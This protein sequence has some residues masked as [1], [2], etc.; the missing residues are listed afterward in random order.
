M[1]LPCNNISLV[2]GL[3]QGF[4]P[5]VATATITP[6][7][8]TFT[9]A[10]SVALNCT[11]P[12]AT[13]T[14]TING[15]VPTTNSAVYS[16]PFTLTNSA[17]VQAIGFAAGYNPSA[18][19]TGSFTVVVGAPVALF[20]AIPTNG[21]SP[22]FVTFTDTST[23]TI[24]NRFWNFG[25]GAT[26][27]ILGT[28][29]GHAYNA[30][31]TNTVTLIVSGPAGAS[32]NTQAKLIVVAN[33]P[34]ASNSWINAAGGGWQDG[35]SWSLGVPPSSAQAAILITNANSKTVTIDATTTNTPAT[36]VINS[37]TVA[38]PLSSTN[39][40][41]LNNA[42][43]A[44]P[45]QVSQ[46]LTI[47]TNGALVV[48]H[49]SV[50]ATNAAACYFGNAGG[51]AALLITN[52]GSVVVSNSVVGFR[53]TSGNNLVLVDGV[54][55]VW[56]NAFNLYIGWGGSG[57]QLLVTNGGAVFSSWAYVGQSPASAASN[58][59]VLISG[60]GSVWSNANSLYVG[61][62]GSGNRLVVTNGG[63]VFAGFGCVGAGN[64]GGTNLV[65]VSG[66]GSIWNAGSLTL[67]RY[68]SG[69]QLLVI[70][71]GAVFSDSSVISS[72]LGGS[73]NG[74]TVSGTGSV[75]NAG[76]LIIGG[77]DSGNQVLVTNGGVVVSDSGTVGS[78]TNS[79]NN[80]ILITGAGSVWSTANQLMIG[81]SACS[82][83]LVIAAGGVAVASNLVV[84]SNASASNN[85]VEIDNGMLLVTAVGG[86]GSLVL[87]SA[88]QGQLILNAG[89]VTVDAL[90]LTNGANSV[91]T[92]NG[93]L[94]SSA[95]TT[96]TNGAGFLVG[97]G[98]E[99]ANFHLAGG[100]HSFANNLEIRNAAYLTGC[101]T[102]NGNVLVDSGGTVLANCPGGQLALTGIVTNNAT[103]I[104]TNGAT[105]AF[106]GLV[107]NN[108]LID[109]TAGSVQFT[110]G[111][112]NNGTIT[113]GVVAQFSASPTNGTAP[114]FVT[115]TETSTGTI[116]NWYWDF[117]DGATTNIAGPG[118]THTYI[119]AATNT[120]T[121]IVSG[122]VG[123]STNTQANL[124]LVTNNVVT[125]IVGLSGNLAFGN[126]TT[127][128][129]ATATLTITNAGNAT[130][131]VGSI[132][133]PAGFSGAFSGPVV[134][135][136]AQDV[137]VTF[138]PVLVT[139]YN[140]TLTVNSDATSGLN[141]LAASGTGT[142]I[143]STCPTLTAT[144]FFGGAGD[145]RGTAIVV[146]NGGLFVTGNVQPESQSAG[147]TSLVLGYSLP[148]T[149]VPT[150][151][152]TFGSGSDFYGIAAAS[153]GIFAAGWSYSLTT[154]TA[155]GKE[156][157]TIV[158]QFTL[159]GTDGPGP[160]GSVWTAGS[161]G[162]N[163]PLGALF[164]YEGV[165]MFNASGSAN[166][167]GTNYIYAVGGGQPCS[168]G[169]YFVVKYD[170]AGNR[171]GAATD[172][173]VGI[174]FGTCSIPSPGG[175]GANGVTFLNGNVYLVGTTGWQFED[176]NNRPAIWQYNSN[177]NL[178]ARWRDTNDFGA[179]NAAVASS[180]AVYAVGYVNTP[181]VPG[182]EDYLIVKYDELGNVLWR[183]T[184]GGTNTDLLTGVV[185]V[186]SRLF[187]VG[188]TR[189]QGA[190]GADAVLMEID[191]ATGTILST[192]LFGGAQDDLAN[193]VATDGF[194]LYLVGET[195]SFVIG[196][197]GAG[198]NDMFVLR[199][200]L[201]A[202]PAITT[203][204][205]LPAGTA[206][207]AYNL[208]LLG[209]GGA[210]PYTWS[211]IS[212][213]LPAGLNLDG[214]TGLISGTPTNAGSFSF[215]VQVTDHNSST[216][217]QTFTLT[218]NTLV[219][220]VSGNLA[221]GNVTTGITATAT[222]TIT[223]AGTATLT[224]SGIS[225]PAG[226][227]GAFSGPVPAGSAQG[228]TV[229]FAPVLVTNYSGAFTVN[230]DAISGT[231]TLAV[232]GT[233][234]PPVTIL[235]QAAPPDGGTVTGGGTYPV[236]TNILITATS[237]NGWT[238]GVWND[239]D[240]NAARTITVPVTNFIFTATFW[241]YLP[242][243]F[244]T[245]AGGAGLSGT[246]DGSG[247]LARFYNP[248]GVAVDRAGTVYVA[249]TFNHTIR[250]ITPFGITTTLAGAARL[251]AGYAD[252]TG[253]NA[254]FN[255]PAGIAMGTN[256]NLYVV[257][258]D[259][260]LIR[261]ITPAGV[262]STFAGQLA[263][264]FADG[265]GT[266]AVFN[267]PV[268][269]AADRSGN[270]YV[271]DAGNAVIR[272]ITPAGVVTTLAGAPGH[273]GYADGTGTNAWF[274]WPVG[275]AVDTTGT[276]YVAD[277][278]NTVIRRVTA[279]GAVTTLAGT[280]GIFGSADGTG[281]AAHFFYPSGVAVDST[282]NVYVADSN[283][284]NT[285]R[286]ITPAGVVTTLAGLPP[287]V[288]STDGIGSAVRFFDPYGVAVD[289]AGNL[290][291]ADM[292][293]KT[294]RK[295]WFG[296]A[297]N[298]ALTVVANPPAGGSVTGAGAYPIGTNVFL[299]ATPTNNWLFTGWSDGNSNA[300][301]LVT[302]PITNFIYIANFVQSTAATPLLTPAGGTFTDSV[303][304]AVSCA[305][306]GAI[307]TYTTDG[308]V[309]TTNSMVAS[310]SFTL[311]NS[312]LV[313]ALGFA[314]GY[315]LSP[316]ATGSF[317]VVR[318][319]IITTDS[320]LPTGTVGA[321]YNLSLTATGGAPPYVW[322]IV[323]NSLPPG[324]SLSGS[325]VISG[326]PV[327]VFGTDN[328]TVQVADSNNVV[329][330]LP[331]SLFLTPPTVFLNPPCVSALH[332][333]MNGVVLPALST[334]VATNLVWDWG[335]G[336]SNPSWFPAIH[337]YTV[338]S[339]YTIQVTAYYDDGTTD[340]TAQSVTVGPGVLTGCTT[341][342]ITA[343][344]G[345]SVSYAASVGSGT[346]TSGVPVTLQQT[347]DTAGG[348][349]T[350]IPDPGYVFAGWLPTDGVSGIPSGTPIDTNA[351]AIDV[352]IIS[353]AQIQANFTVPVVPV[354]YRWST[355]AGLAGNLGSVDS[356]GTAARFRAPYGVTVAS[357]TVAYVTDQL[358][359]TIRELNHGDGLSVSTVAG[360]VGD[361][362]SA[363][364]PASAAQFM[365]P[366]GLAR[367]SAGN[368]YVAD[369]ANFTIRQLTWDTTNLIW[370]AST[371]AGSADSPGS[372]DGPGST[373]QFSYP[374]GV[375]VDGVGNVY[376]AD[377]GNGTIRKLTPTGSNWMVTTIAGLAENYG[378]TDGTNS[379]ARFE[380]P[381]G[382]TVDTNG[383][384][385]VVD[386]DNDTLRKLTPAGSNWVVSTIAGQVGVR[387]SADGTNS[388]ALFYWP[389]GIAA[390]GAGNLYVADQGNETI[391]K[392][393]PAGPDWIVTTIGGL[394]GNKGSSDGVNS[395]AQF[396]YPAGLAVDTSGNVFV[397]D[398]GN[399]TVRLGQPNA[400]SPVALPVST[401]ASGTFTNLVNVTLTC[402]TPG[403]AIYYTTDGTDPQTSGTAYP[404]SSSFQIYTS[405][406]VQAVGVLNF[407][408]PSA[409]A[410]ASFTVV[411]TPAAPPDIAPLGGS[412]S[413]FVNV[414]LSC[415]TPGSWIWYTTD[416]TDP[417][418]SGTAA[419][420]YY[421][422]TL[423]NSATVQA[424]GFANGYT[425]S[426][427]ATASFA[428]ATGPVTTPTISPSGGPVTNSVLVTLSCA[429]PSSWL[430]YTSDG[431]DPITSGTASYYYGPFWLY[432]S[433]TI[434]AV[435]LAYG[436]TP[437]LVV[438]ASFTVVNTPAALP[439]ISTSPTGTIFTNSVWVY[440]SCGT[441]S[442]WLTYT[443][444]GSTPTSNSL[445]FYGWFQLTNSAAVKAVGFAPGYTPSPVATTNF[446]VLTVPIASPP[447]ITPP[448]GF[449]SDL[450]Q[451]TMTSVTAGATIAYT[452]DGSLPTTNSAV[453][454]G[455]LI[456]THP[457][458]VRAISWASGHLNSA[459]T[460][461]WFDVRPFIL[462]E[463]YQWTT[464]VGV[465]GAYGYADG[466]DQAARFAYPI[467]TVVD[468]SGRIFVVDQYDDSIRQLTLVGTNW[469]VT[470]IAGSVW[471]AGHV[472]G[473]NSGA[474]FDFPNGIAAD[475]AGNLFV[476]DAGSY[477]I[478]KATAVG[479]DWVV[480]TIA[481]LPYSSGAADGA[482][483]D[484]RFGNPVSMAV[485]PTGN[486]YVADSGY[487]TIRKLALVGT[488]WVVTTIAGLASSYGSA[489]G[490]NGDAQFAS[491]TGLAA[492]GAGNLF[493]ADSSNSTIR[494]LTPAGTNWVVTTIAG[495]AGFPGSDDGT[496]S[497][498]R[499]S[500]P[501]G[502]AV[503]PSGNLFV[504]DY[505]NHT[506]RKLTPMGTNW[507]VTTIGG[508]AQN[509]GSA[510]GTNSDARFFYPSGVAVDAAG[511]LYVTD[512]VNDTIRHGAPVTTNTAVLTVLANPSNAGSVTGGGSYTVGTNVFITAAP[513][514]NW[515]FAAWSDGN[516]NPVRIVTIPPTNI[517]FTANFTA[518]QAQLVVRPASR[519]FGAV[520][521]GQTNTQNFAVINTGNAT[522]SG[523]ASVGAPFAV[524]AGS[525]Y[526]VAAGGTGTVVVAFLPVVGGGVTNPV[527][528]ASNGGSS[529]NLVTGVG[530][531]LQAQLVVRP[532]SRDFG[533]VIIGQTNTQNF[534]VINTGNATLSG[535]ASVGAPFAVSAGSPYTV[536]AG[537]TGTVAV[538]FLPVGS[539]GVSNNVIFASNG[540]SS[541]NLVTGVGV[542]LQVATPVITPAGG[543]FTNSVA[544]TLSCTTPGATLTY[545][546]DGSLP[547]ISSPVYTGV[548]TLTNSATVQ[549]LGVAAGY[550]PSAIASDSFTLVTGV[551][552]ATVTVQA[553]PP[554]GGTVSGGGTYPVGAT[555]PIAASATTLFRGALQAKSTISLTGN[556]SID[557]YDS[558]TPAKSTSGLYD[559]T[560]SQ[561]N[562]NI[563]TL[564]TVGS[565][566]AVG[567]S[568]A[569]DGT[570]TTGPGG[571]VALTG[572]ATV[573]SLATRYATV[574]AATA[575][576]Y[577]WADAVSTMPD[578]VLPGELATAPSLGDYS[579]GANTVTNLGTVSMT[580]SY[581]A[582]SFVLGGSAVVTIQGDVSLFVSGA[583]SIGG[584]AQLIIP[585][586][587]SLTIYAGG[588]VDVGGN[589]VQNLSSRPSNA[590]WYGLRT[591]TAW[592]LH[593][594]AA[595]SGVVY[596]PAAAL[597]YT[598]TANGSG[599]L[600][601][602]SINFGGTANFHYDESLSRASGGWTFTGWN[603][604]NLSERRT[605]T[606]PATNITYT[607]NF[608]PAQMLAPDLTGALLPAP[609]TNGWE[610]AISGT[611]ANPVTGSLENLIL[612]AFDVENVGAATAS[613]SVV[614]FY[615]SPTPGFDPR[616]AILL[617][618]ATHA[619][620]A[621]KP[622][623]MNTAL[624]G[625]VAP[626][627]VD[628]G[629]MYLVAVV[630]ATH[631]VAETDE[632][633]NQLVVGPLN[634]S[635][636]PARAALHKYN[637][638]RQ[639]LRTNLRRLK[640]AQLKAAR[641]LAAQLKA[642]AAKGKP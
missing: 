174:N 13:V 446:N 593:G 319:P 51:N 169:A 489:D 603:D 429:T 472:D 279:A 4:G 340:G 583:V 212:N 193:G 188:Y 21:T 258:G 395:D 180:H 579:V 16:S 320:L 149:N 591:S 321:A 569:V 490:T 218:I 98:V 637:Q 415:S 229:T 324:L 252:G 438:T 592:N 382:I 331:V 105:L 425:P 263:P 257:D 157:K 332:V 511:N 131:T 202:A 476:A 152:R 497:D 122:P 29:I 66:T 413:N 625:V 150:W 140:G 563:V 558:S 360:L 564:A 561:A 48:N 104:A 613:N 440:L 632:T 503:D 530:E 20:S 354:V 411:T 400:A 405:A 91:L 394:A 110:G 598:G 299:T 8:G 276:V 147:D 445:S 236:G 596:A 53:T 543:T 253:T 154:D 523:T 599:A 576:G 178:L 57:N 611:F 367:D 59:T 241:N 92:F 210:P 307:V 172:S 566:V 194:D 260:N 505:S 355:I 322:S 126:V 22:L 192:D 286:R 292:E 273:A 19:A 488:N 402:A 533:A 343:G 137:T 227:S 536:A 235:I 97:D 540:G 64:G 552:L 606:V 30:A 466:T 295:G 208:P 80:T 468:G 231:N 381:I 290:Y 184:A 203:S 423:T 3:V 626:V 605:V 362:G 590:L 409:V 480:T 177:L 287:T 77:H 24:T 485:D 112:I 410:T 457:A 306:P 285:I 486:V 109:T 431:T 420:Y 462:G 492:D 246:N 412:F 385:F 315:D 220:G 166:E 460:D 214:A 10:V 610:A 373:A 316:I 377:Y 374:T 353:N 479:P 544:V 397:T 289:D 303:L 465:A 520:I 616:T 550:N 107:V 435:G 280:A 23:G 498:A 250:K 228:V 300:L 38:A 237:T 609:G 559:A 124:I 376:V 291:V 426:L 288:G 477:T 451:I 60:P 155:G 514:A 495:L 517:T 507:V 118:I 61:W 364:G 264:G 518:L 628:V 586:G 541:T 418:T 139:N 309:P 575:A 572:S 594:T 577:V 629:A 179:F 453:Y 63:K 452:T 436:F 484:A 383:N 500:Y 100:V 247:N 404:Y 111:L 44:T 370:V 535:T 183:T 467:G 102:I 143:C 323:S 182:T 545:T 198:Q 146:T 570:I 225:Y 630:D 87:G 240:T 386:Q 189:S 538:A 283:Y 262:V 537:G 304:V 114:L 233:G 269:L 557:S 86:D 585:A 546:T 482:N 434:N 571:A 274:N 422:F 206:G 640:A 101:G 531:A 399:G 238:F 50:F 614:Q 71:G 153:T 200:S 359:Y 173:S 93:G 341:W 638:T 618:N 216:A 95:G 308:S 542:A 138:A 604:S 62:S 88:G 474:W 357:P 186:G 255:F 181:S 199:Y 421:S 25:D 268:G 99:L 83:R 120:V 94:L 275:V 567:G 346:V 272:Q 245:L 148:L 310:G 204:N 42:G 219:I 444:D 11:T 123:D 459:E 478:R 642:A 574:A 28:N 338:A 554:S 119:A 89:T 342:T 365:D 408:P 54:G 368:L 350:A 271:A 504:V 318:L 113:P 163:A 168:Y 461:A 45:L 56:S 232:S 9:N 261:Q 366:S 49:S 294:I 128:A 449:F 448:G 398:L 501:S 164:S 6:A 1:R 132:S 414:S 582:S 351:A 589:G 619:V 390:D 224:V 427:V 621:L 41:W 547:T 469:V 636:L 46:S 617:T 162:T 549:A 600:S 581:Q 615:L 401:P 69:N 136:G 597:S 378:S 372:A 296:V 293:N 78:N 129:T 627:G 96:V 239:G 327:G 55:S 142:P 335:D 502:I 339:N 437:S 165:E 508:L 18:I 70:N 267:S 348:L 551:M 34:A 33:N 633:N 473:T 47:E 243:T 396:D 145:Q 170:T 305:T 565:A 244:T 447:E 248:K 223:N 73:S 217:A 106:A 527:S 439:S 345:G 555:V 454:T 375:A 407:Y 15:P 256:G 158:S 403:A 384:V 205:V 130:L 251:A 602:N 458:T 529:T 226:F 103:M 450:V 171:I 40:L 328:F 68:S 525:S 249:D 388:A 539:G 347:P 7:G 371:I 144:N 470:T 494:M 532:A 58:N 509:Y 432:N 209:G 259:N 270:L 156:V 379:A 121:L 612:G 587:S 222:L 278:N 392:L 313:Q 524:S 254:V 513:N 43:N 516:T 456:L 185:L 65:M 207:A 330:T 72:Q 329:T 127:G 487:S 115:F 75:W 471:S 522:L 298:V 361:Y 277:F 512:T 475:S 428:V 160:N 406:T 601:G 481:G 634:L 499:F 35:P 85:L 491:P 624:F 84:G 641:Q 363:D 620:P 297:P 430:K 201:G 37:L 117:G 584:N 161:N 442:A 159:D 608:T 588:T 167:S 622:G 284:N 265:T 639:L 326:T 483:S 133:Y 334:A 515:R 52:G 623:G 493:V 67:G 337:T 344:P 562:G 82:N 195:K 560:K 36:M 607:A 116:T 416:G 510:D 234:I 419:Y 325:G 393:T 455:A 190:G 221:F 391:R 553:N 441:P 568:A 281:G 312:A 556:A 521:I 141:T 302:V 443:T 380:S 333:N 81:A 424:V 464:P 631:V 506:I 213:S 573:G 311:T 76:S 635:Q 389:L 196:G 349:L 595:W 528:F 242:Y 39:T 176:P 175:S 301:R 197:N 317:T 358:N 336:Q 356:Y 74:V 79:G 496:N 352:I 2:P 5:T 32:T 151:S 134:A 519:D 580:S 14:Y 31:G 534:A 90:W 369:A 266:N 108:G 230:S 27:N 387:G 526:T 12:G 282:G 463:I 433:A 17:L 417:H 135:G 26:T 215:T 314:A 548:F 191:P 187:A 578:V 211:V 125:R